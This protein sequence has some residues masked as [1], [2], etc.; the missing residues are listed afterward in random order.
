MPGTV[1]LD[2]ATPQLGGHAK[3][4]YRR[5]GDALAPAITEHIADFVA[6]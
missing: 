3:A 4:S 2:R 1:E 5:V 6:V